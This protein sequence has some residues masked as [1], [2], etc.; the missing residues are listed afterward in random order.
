ML[1]HPVRPGRQQYGRRTAVRRDRHRRLPAW[2]DMELRRQRDLLSEE[3][4]TMRRTQSIASSLG[5]A[6]LLVVCACTDLLNEDPKGFTTTDTFYKSGADLNSA[7]IAIYNALRGLQGQAQWTTLEL[8]SD[9]A[10]ADTREPNLGTNGPDFLIME[11]S[12]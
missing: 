2:P 1:L 10:R 11:A 4:T 7:T 5:L 6:A 3:E 8:A 9:Q 12:D